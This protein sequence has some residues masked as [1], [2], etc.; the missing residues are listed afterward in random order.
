MEIL[1]F[2]NVWLELMLFKVNINFV[3]ELKSQYAVI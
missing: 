1:L 2:F 3:L